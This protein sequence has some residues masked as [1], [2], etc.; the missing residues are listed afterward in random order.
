MGVFM[1]SAYGWATMQPIRKIFFSLTITVISVLI[2]FSIGGVEM[3]QVL[4]MEL[5]SK[6]GFLAGFFAFLV[7]MNF[8][9]VGYLIITIFLTSWIVALLIYRHKGYEKTGFKV[10]TPQAG[11]TISASAP[12]IEAAKTT[13]GTSQNAGERLRTVGNAGENP[14][15]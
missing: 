2:A 4:G 9:N 12:A 13:D 7:N 1:R 11:A 6:A 10:Q 3:L 14:R 8:G 15:A 5:G